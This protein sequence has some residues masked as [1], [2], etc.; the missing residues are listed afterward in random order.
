VSNRNQAH[1]IQPKT[2]TSPNERLLGAKQPLRSE[3]HARVSNVEDEQTQNHWQE[4]KDAKV[5][6]LLVRRGI[7]DL[8]VQA[9]ARVVGPNV[10]LTDTQ[11]NLD[12]ISQRKSCIKLLHLLTH[13]SRNQQS[14]RR[15]A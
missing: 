12:S 5:E 3:N 4:I 14:C 9:L 11:A 6:L 15:L 10:V 7:L 1:R 13:L 2:H 8:P